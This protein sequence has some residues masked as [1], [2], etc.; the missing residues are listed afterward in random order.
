MHALQPQL[1]PPF[2][3]EKRLMSEKAFAGHIT[4]ARDAYRL[5]WRLNFYMAINLRDFS[6]RCKDFVGPLQNLPTTHCVDG[7]DL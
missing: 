6:A 4:T 3:N 7:K 2:Y 5:V 1:P